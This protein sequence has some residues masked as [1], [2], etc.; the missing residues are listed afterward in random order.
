MLLL[1]NIQ[2]DFKSL[3]V[4]M[5][6]IHFL[7]TAE[8]SSIADSSTL[9]AMVKSL[10]PALLAELAKKK[11]TSTTSSSKGS[12]SSS[13]WKRP[14]SP[15]RAEYSKSSRT[16]ISKSSSTPKVRPH[17]AVTGCLFLHYFRF[18]ADCI[19]VFL[20]GSLENIF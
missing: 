3:G 13:S 1:C 7:P 6:Y 10:A 5:H 11:S 20:S 19:V 18:K 12:S 15:K 4:L 17:I 8:L 2:F 16:S 14:P 9:K